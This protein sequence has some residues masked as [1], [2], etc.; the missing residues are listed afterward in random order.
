[1]AAMMAAGLA[2]SALFLRETLFTHVTCEE[3]VPRKG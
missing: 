3:A 1:M 2:I